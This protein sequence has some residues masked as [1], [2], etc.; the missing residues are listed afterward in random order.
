[1]RMSLNLLLIVAAVPACRQSAELAIL[2]VPGTHRSVVVERRPGHAS[3]SE[4]HRRVL[5]RK[6]TAFLGSFDV[7]TAGTWRF[8]PVSERRELP[9]DFRGR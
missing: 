8:I 2:G 6:D 1:M 9:T 7:D 4:Y 5:L 3:L